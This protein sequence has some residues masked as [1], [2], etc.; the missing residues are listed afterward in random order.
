MTK[1][2]FQ[3]YYKQYYEDNK[4]QLKNRNDETIKTATYRGERW[5][6]EEEFLLL[7]LRE[8]GFSNI[9]IAEELK[10][11]LR[12][13]ELKYHRLMKKMEV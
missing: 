4:E 9:E 3:E 10:R 11:S 13:I 2:Y 6:K 1:E 5:T 12:G 7:E 8:Q